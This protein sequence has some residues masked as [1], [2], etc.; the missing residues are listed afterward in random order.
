MSTRTVLM[1]SA[2]IELATGVALIAAPELVA[3][4]LL[5]AELPRTGVAVARLAGFGL[6]AL[7]LA[8]WPGGDD[9]TPKAIRALFVYNLLA[10]LFLGYLRVGAGFAGYLL[11]PACVV[12]ILLAILL[13]GPAYQ[14]VSAL[15]SSR[16]M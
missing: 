13:A 15:A 2:A 16:E 3:R 11:W 12:H 9:P 5:G 7:G 4:L 1:A 10:G 8:C 6:F 14:T